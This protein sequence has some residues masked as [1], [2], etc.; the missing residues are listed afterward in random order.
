LARAAATPPSKGAR[1]GPKDADTLAL[2]ND[3]SEALGLDVF[4]ADEGGSGELRI[5][6]ATLE[7]LDDLCR[8]LTRAG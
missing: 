4:I 5:Q 6:Y 8:R 2:E 1:G 3:L 7:Q